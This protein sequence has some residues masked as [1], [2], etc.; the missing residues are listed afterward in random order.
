VTVTNFVEHGIVSMKVSIVLKQEY[1]EATIVSWWIS[2][3]YG[4][5]LLAL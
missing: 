5:R 2:F 3:L 1:R 4:N